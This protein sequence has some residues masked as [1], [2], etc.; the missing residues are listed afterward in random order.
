VQAAVDDDAM[1]PP[2]RIVELNQPR[3]RQGDHALID[4][5]LFAPQRPAFVKNRMRKKPPQF[6][7]VLILHHELQVMARVS[8]VRTGEFQAEMLG[9][10]RRLPFRARLGGAEIIH[11]KD[12]GLIA[13]IRARLMISRGRKLMPKKSRH[14]HH[15]APFAFG[16][17]YELR[18][19]EAVP[20][21]AGHPLIFLQQ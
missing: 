10:L 18:R 3:L 19:L 13:I 7:R 9:D 5:H 15:L 1:R 8:F 20:H 6:A 2:Q 11:P 21:F 17:G 16:K 4:G 12:P 14:R